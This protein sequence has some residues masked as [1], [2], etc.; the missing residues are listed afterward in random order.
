[1]EVAFLVR[2]RGVQQHLVAE[3]L[4]TVLNKSSPSCRSKPRETAAGQVFTQC[5]LSRCGKAEMAVPLVHAADP[6]KVS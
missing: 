3:I 1:V 2:E 5:V 4:D 6:D